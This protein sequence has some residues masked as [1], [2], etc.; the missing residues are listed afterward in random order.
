[1]SDV[2]PVTN[3]ADDG[4]TVTTGQ[5]GFMAPNTSR[6][7][8][9]LELSCLLGWDGMGQ[10]FTSVTTASM[11]TEGVLTEEESHIFTSI[12]LIAIALACPLV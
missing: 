4:R 6:V 2:I 7:S 8:S 9:L 5:A 3:R 1:M 11:V 12:Y 10:A